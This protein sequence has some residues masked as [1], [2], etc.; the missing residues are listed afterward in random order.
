MARLS[1]ESAGECGGPRV[2][3]GHGHASK[4]YDV[5]TASFK[6]FPC[7]RPVLMEYNALVH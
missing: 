2:L 7:K 1:L 4:S 3:S 5:T 6:R